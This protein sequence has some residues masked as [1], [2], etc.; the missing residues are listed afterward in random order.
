MMHPSLLASMLLRAYEFFLMAL[1][2]SLLFALNFV[3][4]LPQHMLI[5]FGSRF[6]VVRAT[7]ER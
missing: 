2:A 7:V 4:L 3:M 5:E 6:M 1:G